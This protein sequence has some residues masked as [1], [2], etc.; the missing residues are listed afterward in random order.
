[1]VEAGIVDGGDAKTHGIGMMSDARWAQV[2]KV[3]AGVYPASLDARRGY[4][5]QFVSPAP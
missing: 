5:L 4:T 3:G 1:M 2:L